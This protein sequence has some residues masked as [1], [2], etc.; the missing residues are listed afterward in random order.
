MPACR[1]HASKKA[2][3][4]TRRSATAW[5]TLRGTAKDAAPS[6]GLAR[7]QVGAY[8]RVGKRYRALVGTRFKTVSKATALKALKTVK[9]TAAGA[10]KLKL[11]KLTAGRWTFRARAVDVAGNVGAFATRGMTLR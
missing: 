3:A 2:C 7:V 10:W 1:A 5:R 9:P 11:P 6:T 8:R 4:K